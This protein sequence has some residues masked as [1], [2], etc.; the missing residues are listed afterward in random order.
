MEL[1]LF[2][3]PSPS[4]QALSCRAMGT[5]LI[6]PWLPGRERLGRRRVAILSGRGCRIG[7]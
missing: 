1:C 4:R 2:C 7:R 5:I 3:W 6:A